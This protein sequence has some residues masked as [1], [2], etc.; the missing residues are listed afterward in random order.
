MATI[1]PIGFLGREFMG[2]IADCNVELVDQAAADNAHPD[3]AKVTNAV[4][5]CAD[6]LGSVGPELHEY[7]ATRPGDED[8]SVG[9]RLRQD[10]G[11]T[12]EAPTADDPLVEPLAEMRRL[13]ELAFSRFEPLTGLL[14]IARRGSAMPGTRAPARH[15]K[16]QSPRGLS[17]RAQRGGAARR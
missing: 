6:I 17:S 16:Q 11:G 7:V 12:V 4:K 5:K 2:Y 10:S 13:E 3:H 1:D 14:L 9:N 8:A 15:G